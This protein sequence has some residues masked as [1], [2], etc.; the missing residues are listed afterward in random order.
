MDIRP[1]ARLG[2]LALAAALAGCAGAKPRPAPAAPALPERRFEV[3]D[4][5]AILLRLPAEWAASEVESEPGLPPTVRLQPPE[6]A[7]LVLLSP[8]WDPENPEAPA[9]AESAQALTELARRKMGDTAAEKEIA[10]EELSGDGVHGYWFEATDAELVARE[11]KPGE[12]RH[13]VQGAV[14]VGPLLLVFALLDQQ[15]GPQRQLVLDAVRNARHEPARG[16]G[17]EG[18]SPAGTVLRDDPLHVEVPGRSWSVL[19]DLPGFATQPAHT[20]EHGVVALAADTATN[21]VAS[22]MVR[23][24]GPAGDARGCRE[25]DL[26]RIRAQFRGLEALR[27]WEADG[28]ALAEWVIPEVDG[29]PLRQLNAHSWLFRDGAC[30]HV[31]LSTMD[32][33]PDDAERLRRILGTVRFAEAL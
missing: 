10:L 19:V 23:G 18:G 15:A 1:P 27:T 29:K 26:A 7:F 11:P 9:R 24:A 12:W 21:A 30:V 13:V 17:A 4:R 32:H 33:Q 8:L 22:V 5:G 20:S 16:A 25:D 6:G 14:A 3:G 28:A 31:H 2:A